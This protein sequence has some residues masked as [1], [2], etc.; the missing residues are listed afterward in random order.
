MM[1]K[2]IAVLALGAFFAAIVVAG[3]GSSTSSNST[4]SSSPGTSGN[5]EVNLLSW[6]GTIQTT[7]EQE[8]WAAKF[9]QETGYKVVYTPKDLSS[10]IIAQVVAQKANP[11]YDVIMC[12]QGPLSIA[13]DQGIFA[14]LDEA[15]MPNMANME[16]AAKQGNYV[17]TYADSA[18]LLYNPAYF[19][20][21]G[22]PA[23]NSWADLL[24]PKFKGKIMI[25]GI[26]N[27]EGLFTFVE[28]AN[29]GGGGIDNIDPGYANLK[30]LA[31]LVSTWPDN[32][33]AFEQGFHSGETVLAVDDW[34]D[35]ATMVKK[36][37]PIKMVIPKEG[38]Y[39]DNAA[40][41]IV[42]NAPNPKG[43]EA[44]LNFMIS[45]GF[46][47]YQSDTFGKGSYNTTVVP[48]PAAAS[49]TLSPEM[50]SKLK[51]LDW[52]AV[53]PLLPTWTTQWDQI[54]AGS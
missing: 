45:E 31:P 8:G 11:Q 3:C 33:T 4:S 17:L 19:Q 34:V 48:D 42:A 2:Y 15:A 10:Q 52:K 6:G 16:P 25:P 40:A 47:K 43:A 21:N 51:Q 12:S 20:K 49:Y 32:M 9:E 1:K 18:A 29:L 44:L 39:A 22:L 23:P 38:A 5:K 35:G 13:A 36:G 54:T 46:L 27:T 14:T 28:M 50:V 7:F 53:T 37:L 26:S 24:N 30:K 41:A